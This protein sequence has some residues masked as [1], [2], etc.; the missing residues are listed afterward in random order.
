M[1]HD[2]GY[3]VDTNYPPHMNPPPY[4]QGGMESFCPYPP[5]YAPPSV[6]TTFLQPQPTAGMAISM[7]SAP[8]YP[9]VSTMTTTTQHHIVVGNRPAPTTQ[10]TVI[11]MQAAPVNTILV[12]SSF[13]GTPVSTVCIYCRQ[14]V[15]TRVSYTTGA[16]PWLICAGLAV[17]GCWLGCC[18]I[19]FCID[20]IKDVNHFCPNC[21]Q[22][23][24]KHKKL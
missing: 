16:L 12:T 15:I 9:A 19:P 13:L 18:L 24:A 14:Y 11:G 5:P 1:N 10:A 21:N 8:P 3:A 7:P 6:T 2:K 17:L 23:I 4:S 20:D 22:L